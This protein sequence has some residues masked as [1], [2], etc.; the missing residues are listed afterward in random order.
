MSVRTQNARCF[1]CNSPAPPP[2]PLPPRFPRSPPRPRLPNPRSPK[3]SPAWPR[4]ELAS[5]ARHTSVQPKTLVIFAL[6]IVRLYL[7]IMFAYLFTFGQIVLAATCSPINK[8]DCLGS[9]TC[10]HCEL[11]TLSFELACDSSSRA[12]AT[13]PEVRHYI[14]SLTLACSGRTKPL[15]LCRFKRRRRRRRLKLKPAPTDKGPLASGRLCPPFPWPHRFD[16]Q[17]LPAKWL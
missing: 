17:F 1:H 10:W 16:I 5:A 6:I 8:L 9:T 2:P 7:L 15:W 3:P 14:C 4:A 11:S 13:L 12:R